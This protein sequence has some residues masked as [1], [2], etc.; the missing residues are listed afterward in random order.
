MTEIN[1]TNPPNKPLTNNNTRTLEHAD[2]MTFE[3][4]QAFVANGAQY[5]S[6]KSSLTDV[7]HSHGC[8]VDVQVESSIPHTMQVQVDVEA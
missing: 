4:E 2:G 7:S 1:S 5:S 8:S 6:S 3:P